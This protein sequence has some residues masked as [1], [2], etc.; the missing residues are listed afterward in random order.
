MGIRLKGEQTG[1]YPTDRF[2][3]P[4]GRADPIADECVERTFLDQLTAQGNCDYRDRSGRFPLPR[5]DDR[6]DADR[7]RPVQV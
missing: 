3:A 7:V 5:Y 6:R 2:D 4:P 1:R